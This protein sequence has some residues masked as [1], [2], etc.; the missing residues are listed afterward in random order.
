MPR[1]R[2]VVSIHDVAPP[3][4]TQVR[5]IL[6]ALTAVGVRHRSLLVIPNLQGA[7]PIDQDPDFC[8][9]LRTQEQDGDEIVLHGYE[10]V[11]V[12]LPTTYCDRFK[13]RWF[14]QGEGEFLSLSYAEARRRLERGLEI[15]RRAGFTC[16][17]WVAPAWLINQ[18]GLRAV[19]DLGFRYT[20]SYTRVTDLTRDS[21]TFAP[22][23]VFGPGRL[24]EDVGL[25][26]Q[27]VVS[28]LLMRASIVRVVLHPPCIDNPVRFSR[29]L[30]MI[31][32]H[33]ANSRI[34]T[35]GQLVAN[36]FL[37]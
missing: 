14:T 8:G 19:R 10:H 9:W 11:G 15:V 12:G 27:A 35:Y 32:S 18:E 26:A 16:E 22:S 1:K 25:R 13:N 23:L 20:N 21:S 30:N 17:G 37:S 4:T 24:N 6:D 34:S 29:V 31:Q 36:P 28:R 3:H 33:L 2:L 5:A 7:C